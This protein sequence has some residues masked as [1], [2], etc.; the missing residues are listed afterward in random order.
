VG[1][2]PRPEALDAAAEGAEAVFPVKA[3]DLMPGLAGP[4]LGAAL[5]RMERDWIASG[6]TLGAEDLLR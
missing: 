5:A 1:T 3:R 2:R 4:E 6:F